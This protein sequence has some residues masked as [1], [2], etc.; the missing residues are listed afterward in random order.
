MGGAICG[1]LLF[2]ASYLQQ[3]GISVYP[4]DAAASGRSGFL[5]ATYVVMVSVYSIFAERK[6]HLPIVVATIGCM[7]GMYLLC[8]SNGI[9]RLYT[10]DIYVFLCA[11][12]FAIHLLV[13][14]K[15]SKSS[16]IKMSFMQF[17]VCGLLSFICMLIFE[18]PSWSVIL[19]SKFE[20]M[21]AGIFSSGIAYTLQIIGQKGTNPTAASIILSL[22]SVFALLAGWAIDKEN[23]PAKQIFGCILV[24]LS[25]ILAQLPDNIFSLKKSTSQKT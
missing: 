9:D 2:L 22:E 1:A 3:F 23:L 5:T 11:V 13:I 17:A 19:D 25:V 21:Y 18:T 14:D 12:V 16:G 24:F 7:A 20:I 4:E 10:G 15:F 8:L 6:M